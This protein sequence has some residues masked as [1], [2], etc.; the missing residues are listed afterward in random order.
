[1]QK[2][3][4]SYFKAESVSLVA[5]APTNGT[6]PPTAPTLHLWK[7]ESQQHQHSVTRHRYLTR[8]IVTMTQPLFDL[9]RRLSCCLVV[10]RVCVLCC[11]CGVLDLGAGGCYV[12]VPLLGAWPLI[13]QTKKTILNF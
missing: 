13:D 9:T 5:T 4:C 8:D 7:V 11:V 3:Y 12:K 6:P 10:A 2:A 1:M